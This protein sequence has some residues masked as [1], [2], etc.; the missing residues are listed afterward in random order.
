MSG[1]ER[2]EALPFERETDRK[3]ATDGLPG[4]ADR[5][6]PGGSRHPSL[7][8][9][10][11]KQQKEHAPGL[12]T[13]IM[14][15]EGLLPIIQGCDKTTGLW[16]REPLFEAGRRIRETVPPFGLL[17]ATEQEPGTAVGLIDPIRRHAER[18]GPRLKLRPWNLANR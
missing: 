16:M 4:E 9:A 10:T 7:G 8:L 2:L 3:R 18:L 17:V 12:V 11:G 6:T 14:G 15:I 1:D 13:F 5:F